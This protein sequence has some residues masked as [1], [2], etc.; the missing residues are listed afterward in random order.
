MTNLISF[1]DRRWRFELRTHQTMVRVSSNY[2]GSKNEM[3]TICG[4]ILFL[5]LE[6]VCKDA[7]K[8]YKNAIFNVWKCQFYIEPV[9]MIVILLLT[10]YPSCPF[11]LDYARNATFYQFQ[12]S[13]SDREGHCPQGHSI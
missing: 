2:H 11:T 3:F 4:Y 7:E 1:K 8:W 12:Q 10:L 13:V 9:T 5:T 6:N